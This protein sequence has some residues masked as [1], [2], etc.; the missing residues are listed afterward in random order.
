VKH[1]FIKI[2]P[3]KITDDDGKCYLET[4]TAEI[5]KLPDIPSGFS[6]HKKERS[7]LQ[8]NS[9]KDGLPNI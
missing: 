9:Y 6:F 3:D 2:A 7:A 8:K 5:G 1:F 4:Q